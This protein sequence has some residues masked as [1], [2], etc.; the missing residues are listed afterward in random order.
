MVDGSYF[1][2]GLTRSSM[3]STIATQTGKK[4]GEMNGYVITMTGNEP[5]G[6]TPMSSVCFATLSIGQ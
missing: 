6:A 3:I 4:L 1:V 2:I 5:L